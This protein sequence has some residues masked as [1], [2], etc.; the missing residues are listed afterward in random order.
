M[1]LKRQSAPEQKV[2]SLHIQLSAAD[3][4]LTVVVEPKLTSV[5]KEWAFANFK[6]GKLRAEVK[7]VRDQ[8]DYNRQPARSQYSSAVDERLEAESHHRLEMLAREKFDKDSES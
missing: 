5:C 4:T 7:T 1:L 6:I 8:M 3:S 2:A